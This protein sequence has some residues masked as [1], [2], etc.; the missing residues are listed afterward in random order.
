MT[1]YCQVEQA[2][3][4]PT[5]RTYIATAPLPFLAISPQDPGDE[6][7]FRGAVPRERRVDGVIPSLVVR[8]AIRPIRQQKAKSG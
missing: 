5:H 7:G 4:I 8:F 3:Y 6:A 2:R 1:S